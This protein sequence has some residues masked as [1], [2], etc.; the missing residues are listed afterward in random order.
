MTVTGPDGTHY[1]PADCRIG[2][3]AGHSIVHV[4]VWHPNWGSSTTSALR[5]GLFGGSG[6]EA[7]PDPRAARLMLD[8]ALGEETVATWVGSVEVTDRCPQHAVAMDDLRS[9]VGEMAASAVGP[10]GDPVWTVLRFETEGARGTA[11]TIVPVTPMTA[12][13]CDLHVAVTVEIDPVRA[14]DLTG[15]Q[16]DDRINALEDALSDT[17]REN[18]AGLLVAVVRQAGTVTMYFYLDSVGG[19]GTDGTDVVAGDGAG[20]GVGDGVGAGG[21]AGDVDAVVNTLRACVSTWDIGESSF[22]SGADPSWSAV[23]AFRV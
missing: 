5:A 8:A 3:R 21:S 14:S 20:A 16:V 9:L 11:R 13:T 19:G 10:D 22:S 2:V 1:D 17:V 18:R 6:G 4:T 7:E 15:A 12:P 23:R